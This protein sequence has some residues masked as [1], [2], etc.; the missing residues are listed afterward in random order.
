MEERR[1]ARLAELT[2]PRQR[3]M[4]EQVASRRFGQE[5]E[6]IARYTI[7]QAQ[8]EDDRQSVARVTQ[9]SNDAMTYWRDPQRREQA[10]ALA[11]NETMSLADRQGWAP[12]RAQEATQEVASNILTRIVRQQVDD[13]PVA[14]ARFLNENRG[15]LLPADEFALDDELRK[16]LMDRQVTEYADAWEQGR[17]P[18]NIL[19]NTRPPP[20][21]P[22]VA[23]TIPLSKLPREADGSL[24]PVHAI[25]TGGDTGF[26][27]VPT[28]DG[29]GE[30]LSDEQAL[31]IYRRTGEH[32]GVY[33]TEDAAKAAAE[34]LAEPAD[35]HE[36]GDPPPSEPAVSASAVRASGVDLDR[37]TAYA[38]SR[39]REY[40]A[41][42]DRVTSSAGARGRM[43]VMPATARDPGYGIRPS[44][45]TPE[46]DARLGR[47]YRAKME[48]VYHGDL[49]KMWG[50]YNW[51]P[52][53]LDKAV[54][55]WGNDWL[56]HAPSDT[57]K[58][59]RQ[60]VAAAG[61][62]VSTA[63]VVTSPG[64]RDLGQAYAW[65]DSLGLGYDET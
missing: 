59:V 31:A 2:T 12:E 26:V 39:N 64:V 36:V 56:A 58:Y 40:T 62:A 43:Q 5:T 65:A 21:A 44:N 38:E 9:S 33:A 48:E 29:D 14:A 23:P 4:Y 27:L 41:A 46:D 8:A 50:A 45:G 28:V 63:G 20:P 52:G 3:A 22:V 54:R 25:P 60:N 55:R 6:G 13:D 19:A 11:Q 35:A 61:G 57:Q 42:G 49:A 15:R 10:I 16:P 1:Q 37:I 34:R 53:N 30:A 51:G 24:A 47:E 17:A 7:Q 32:L 18:K